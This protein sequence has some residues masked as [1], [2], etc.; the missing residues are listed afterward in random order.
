[1]TSHGLDKET[2]N[3]ED[4]LSRT[5][6]KECYVSHSELGTSRPIPARKLATFSAVHDNRRPKLRLL[7]SSDFVL[8][9]AGHN[10]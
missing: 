5:Q 8:I 1:M 3:T 4:I 10:T 7:H 2:K 6:C 9:S